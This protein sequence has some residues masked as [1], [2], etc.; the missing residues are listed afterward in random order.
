V[1]KKRSS[2]ATLIKAKKR[3][4]VARINFMEAQVKEKY[5]I[6]NLEYRNAALSRGIPHGLKIKSQCSA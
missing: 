3:N 4:V 1:L 6:F 5:F 2:V